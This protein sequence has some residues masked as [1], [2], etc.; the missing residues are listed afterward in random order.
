MK[1]LRGLLPLVCILIPCVALGGIFENLRQSD[2]QTDLPLQ[3]LLRL[4]L[5]LTD[6]RRAAYPHCCAFCYVL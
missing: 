1:Q 3:L 6:F 4:I 2:P 5:I